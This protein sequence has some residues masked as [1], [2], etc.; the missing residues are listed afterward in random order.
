MAISFESVH[1][2]DRLPN[3]RR[4]PP[5]DLSL[6]HSYHTK[7]LYTLHTS[8][9]KLLEFIKILRVLYLSQ[10]LVPAMIFEG[11][12]SDLATKAEFRARLKVHLCG[13]INPRVFK[14]ATGE[15]VAR[16]FLPSIK[17]ELMDLQR[18]KMTQAPV[19]VFDAVQVMRDCETY[20][21][22]CVVHP[23]VNP[24]GRNSRWLK[25][26]MYRQPNYV[27]PHCP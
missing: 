23:D 1:V 14:G 2:I 11:P 6:L 26:L 20:F 24:Y 18:A 7:H 25:D 21:V 10:A 22:S 4:Q 8:S 12:L 15:D 9:E 19:N 5:R 16:Y 17:N 3:R 27:E 13:S